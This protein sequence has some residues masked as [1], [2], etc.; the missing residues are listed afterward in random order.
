MP[1]EMT[2]DIKCLCFHGNTE[3][4]NFPTVYDTP[5]QANIGMSLY[6]WK[7]LELIFSMVRGTQMCHCVLT[8][9]FPTPRYTVSGTQLRG[10]V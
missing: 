5:I 4:K 10:N 3:I 6:R 7:A 8:P 9:G 2:S 1:G